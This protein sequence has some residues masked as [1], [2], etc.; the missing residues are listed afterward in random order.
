MELWITN[1]QGELAALTGAFLW[2]ASSAAYSLLGQKISPLKLNLFKGLIAIALIFLTLII[3]DKLQ[4][5][6]NSTTINLFLISGILGIGL[7]DTAF[8]SALKNMGA[9][10]TLLM[11]TLSPP[12]TALLALIFLGEQL[13]F[14]AWCGILIT[15]GGVAWV[16]SERTPGAAISNVNIKQGILWAILAAI[17]NSSGAVISRFALLSSDI[18][19][20]L[21]TLFRLIGG[22]TI[23]VLLLFFQKIKQDKSEK[24]NWSMKLVGA[25]FITAFSS[26]YLGIWL[27]QTSLK[28]SPAGIA[29]TLLATSPIFIIPIAAQMGEKISIRSI[30][31]VLVAVVGISLLFTFQ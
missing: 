1:F 18:N 8:F 14:G 6:I 3:S 27:Q 20:L 28:F 31:G 23:V 16:I 19:P 15:V 5:E 10:R 22:T 30:L 21:S 11:E 7:G 4:T 12:M 29:Q 2:A 17:A 26:T 24:F 13:T 9:R 25:I